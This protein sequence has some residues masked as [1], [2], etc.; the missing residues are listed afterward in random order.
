MI[1]SGVGKTSL[2]HLICHS[3]PINNPSWTV[4]CSVEVKLHEYKEGTPH[5][6]TYFI[7]LWDVGGSSSHRNT[8]CVFYNPVHGEFLNI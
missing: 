4:G 8:R 2:V 3:E 6:K 5:Q 1:I 7:E